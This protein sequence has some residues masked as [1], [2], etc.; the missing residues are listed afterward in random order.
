MFQIGKT[1]VSEALIDQDFVC[2]LNACKGACCVEGEAGAPLSKEEAQWLVENQSKIEPFLPK[3]GIEAL[4]TQ[5]AFIELET[6]EYETPLVQDRECAYTHFEPD[7]SAHCGIERAYKAGAVDVQKP[8]SCHLYPVRVQDYS[9]FS[10]VNYHR[11]PI[12]SDACVLGASL[13]VPVYQFV[14]EALIRKF[15]HDWYDELALVAKTF[16]DQN[17]NPSRKVD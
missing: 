12:C 15:G 1:L 4:D 10:A 16:K 8:I 11:W 9:E 17:Q 6:G 7:G 14:K 3:A 13:K 2:N 5:G